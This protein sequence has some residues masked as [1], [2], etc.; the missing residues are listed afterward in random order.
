MA[1][2]K[3]LVAEDEFII[4][5]DLEGTLER[6]GYEVVDVVST[7]EDAFKA[8]IYR[9]PNLVLMDIKLQGNMDG[10]QAAQQIQT[11]L[12]I[13]V[14]YLTAHSDPDTLKRVIHSKT[15]GYLTKPFSVDGLKAAIEKALTLHQKKTG[16]TSGT[17]P[18]V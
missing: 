18:S 2:V 14:V 1:S 8:A 4:A 9:R 16:S 3:I 7:G 12:D 11:H 10:V 5:K 17:P 15:Y 6:L 13:P